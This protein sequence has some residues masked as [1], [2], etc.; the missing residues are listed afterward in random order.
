MS[1]PRLVVVHRRTQL[2]ALLAEHATLSATE[3]FLRTRGQDIAPIVAADEA[4]RRALDE[5]TGAA[6]D[7]WRRAV[8]ER[9]ELSR[10]LFEPDDTIVV[11]GQ[12][13]LVANAAKYLSGQT[14]VGVS[15][16]P[17]GMLCT[18]RPAEIRPFLLGALRAEFSPRGMVEARVDD[19]Q[20]LTA[21][22]EIFVG[23]AGHQS[24]RYRVH[25]GSR[26][27]SQS[28][29][30][31]IVGTGTGSTGWLASL[32]QQTRPGFVLPA[33]DAREL[34]FFVR[35]AWPAAGYGAELV[36][37]LLASDAAVHLRA[38]SSLVAFG[39]GIE[40]DRL[41]IEWGQEVII[42]RAARE[43]RLVSGFVG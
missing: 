26:A 19:G 5:V 33:S 8:V 28:S 11:V 9:V 25:I 35:E 23:D 34:A 12:D 27:E 18:A 22:N 37:G 17:P 20:A 32:W 13:G 6:P 40:S 16:G 7:D 3:F 30:G 15:P 21:L 14:V 36:A 29:S 42:R 31:L 2:E 10:F 38:E 43:L 1:A 41:R 39:D 4:Q 24:A